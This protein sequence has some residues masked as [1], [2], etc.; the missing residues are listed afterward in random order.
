[1]LVLP[2]ITVFFHLSKVGSSSS[3]VPLDTSWN[4]C[5]PTCALADLA[6]VTHPVKVCGRDN[7]P[8]SSDYRVDSICN[9]DNGAN[10]YTCADQSLWAVNKTT[11]YGFAKVWTGTQYYACYHLS[12]VP[13]PGDDRTRTIVV[14]NIRQPT[15]PS[16][17]KSITVLVR[18]RS[19]HGLTGI[20]LT[21]GSTVGSGALLP[22]RYLCLPI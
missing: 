18:C 1:M 10:A 11:S 20:L 3:D 22:L 8:H 9:D 7:K 16:T 6:N 14:Q 2:L 4:C 19:K 15:S 17:I 5:P 13:P 21:F 12:L